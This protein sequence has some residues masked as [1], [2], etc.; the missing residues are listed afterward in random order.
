MND[1]SQFLNQLPQELLVV[2][3]GF[4]VSLLTQIAKKIR[5]R[6]NYDIDPKVLAAFLAIFSG[7]AYAII[8]KVSSEDFL[9]KIVEFWAL[10]FSGSVAIYEL[11]KSLVKKTIKNINTTFPKENININDLSLLYGLIETERKARILDIDFEEFSLTS[12]KNK[13][14]TEN[15]LRSHIFS[16]KERINIEL[17]K[18]GGRFLSEEGI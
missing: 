18:K 6:F 3:G 9:E 7:I 5:D 11:Y 1:F 4:L 10:A 15:D 2:I 8:I 13:K 14:L 16:L 12:I 17:E